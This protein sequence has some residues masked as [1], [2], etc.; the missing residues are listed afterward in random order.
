MMCNRACCGFAVGGSERKGGRGLASRRGPE[1]GSLVARTLLCLSSGFFRR[2][3][4]ALLVG[5]SRGDKRCPFFPQPLTYRTVGREKPEKARRQS[6]PPGARWGISGRCRISN[7]WLVVGFSNT[8]QVVRCLDAPVPS[9]TSDVR[10]VPR[11]IEWSCSLTC[12]FAYNCCLIHEYSLIF[13]ISLFFSY[14]LP[15]SSSPI[16]TLTT[17]LH[18]ALSVSSWLYPPTSP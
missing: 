12:S 13:I 7:H 6:Q 3:A 2:R 16:R 4:C 11:C 5:G 10:I 17:S 14:L 1:V 8:S 18:R 15:S 9:I